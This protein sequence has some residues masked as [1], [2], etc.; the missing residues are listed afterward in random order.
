[1]LSR[2]TDSGQD[3]GV[4]EAVARLI[5][6][7]PAAPVSGWDFARASRRI[8]KSSLPWDFTALPPNHARGRGAAGE[9]GRASPSCM[10]THPYD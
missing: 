9:P 5:D 4:S 8:V 10:V 6:D 1:M 7:A 2:L 3:D